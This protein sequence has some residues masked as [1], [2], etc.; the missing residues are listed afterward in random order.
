MAVQLGDTLV[1]HIPRTGGMW[2]RRNLWAYRKHQKYKSTSWDYT[3]ATY[4]YLREHGW[5]AKRVIVV[6]RDYDS[7]APSAWD[8]FIKL[9]NSFVYNITP[10]AH[11]LMTRTQELSRDEFIATS[12]KLYEE[13]WIRMS[14]HAT[15]IVMFDQLVEGMQLAFPNLDLDETKYDEC[16]CKETNDRNGNL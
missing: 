7:W 13:Y 14:A 1:L 2:I 15:D 8:A 3:H 6:R 12:R 4:P 9:R 5:K 10:D 11:A 16:G